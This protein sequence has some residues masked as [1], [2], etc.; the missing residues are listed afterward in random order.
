[1][2]TITINRPKSYVGMIR[3]MKILI[4]EQEVGT[5]SNGESMTIDLAAGQHELVCKVGKL[6]QPA[7]FSF[8]INT[9]EEK[10][11]DV[12]FK[13]LISYLMIIIAIL[14]ILILTI[15]TDGKLSP[16]QKISVYLTPSIIAIILSYKN[17]LYI[18]QAEI[19]TSP[20]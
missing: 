18:K 12:G 14:L 15:F 6:E 17:A 8:A 11:F 10:I 4:D 16:S 3:K 1:M 20:R 5:L 13:N 9:G 7:R 19:K 2:S